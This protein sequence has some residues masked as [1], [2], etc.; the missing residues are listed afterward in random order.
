MP[1]WQETQPE[2]LPSAEILPAGHSEQLVEPALEVEPAGHDKHCDEPKPS[3][4]K[5]EFALLGPAFDFLPAGQM[6][7]PTARSAPPSPEK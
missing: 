4:A 5:G 7:Q 1:G 3:P 2:A 6:V